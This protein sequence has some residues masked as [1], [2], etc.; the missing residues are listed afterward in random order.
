MKSPLNLPPEM[1][2]FLIYDFRAFF[3]KIIF[4]KNR[5]SMQ[6]WILFIF[7]PEEIT[8]KCIHS[9]ILIHTNTKSRLF[10]ADEAT[11]YND[12]ARLNFSL[13]KIGLVQGPLT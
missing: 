12:N 13:N 2:F 3:E 8:Q 1:N 5:H 11:T 4:W 10:L 6:K 7:C 9:F